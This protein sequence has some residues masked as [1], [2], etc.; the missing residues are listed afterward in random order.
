MINTVIKNNNFIQYI[1]ISKKPI[2][3]NKIFSTLFKP[4]KTKY[5]GHKPLDGRTRLRRDANFDV[6]HI[7]LNYSWIGVVF[8]F[9]LDPTIK[10][11]MDHLAPISLSI[12]DGQIRNIA[13]PDD[14]KQDFFLNLKISCASGLS[15]KKTSFE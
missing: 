10:I 5:I 14:R 1:Q 9:I 3:Y 15:K 13:L 7:L 12:I 11:T 8:K 4:L 6:L 2:R